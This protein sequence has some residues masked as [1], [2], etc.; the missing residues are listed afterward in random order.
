MFRRD[1]VTGIIGVYLE[2]A[3]TAIHSEDP[4]ASLTLFFF[5]TFGLAHAYPISSQY[6]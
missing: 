1:D 2:T 3:S 5:F 4:G 6:A